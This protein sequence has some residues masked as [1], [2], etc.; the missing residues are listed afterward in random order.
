MRPESLVPYRT[1]AR[2]G[3]E[4]PSK[5][6]TENDPLGPS[7]VERA[8]DGSVADAS[9][10]KRPPKNNK[11]KDRQTNGIGAKRQRKKL[12]KAKLGSKLSTVLLCVVLLDS[13][14]LQYHSFVRRGIHNDSGYGNSVLFHDPIRVITVGSESGVAA[15]H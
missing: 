10:A 3:L 5:S 13:E 15:F 7:D 4:S 14:A 2:S 1:L 12:R 8:L 9:P 6:A 11:H